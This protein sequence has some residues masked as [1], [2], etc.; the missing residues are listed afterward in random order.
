MNQHEKI[1]TN[2]I[3]SAKTKTKELPYDTIIT[4]NITWSKQLLGKKNSSHEKSLLQ[5][6]QKGVSI[7]ILRD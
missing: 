1:T 7:E 6:L 5:Y 3:K 2:H 4:H